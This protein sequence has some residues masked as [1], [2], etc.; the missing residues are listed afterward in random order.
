MKKK[1]S[2][3][4]LSLLL[5]GCNGQSETDK[6]PSES[7]V[8]PTDKTTTTTPAYTVDLSDI[9]TELSFGFSGSTLFKSGYDI[10]GFNENYHDFKI[11]DNVYEFKTQMKEKPQKALSK[12]QVS[13]PLMTKKSLIHPICASM[14]WN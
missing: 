8:P 14:N 4:F 3:L 11:G 10:L 12:T 6:L 2:L 1:I 7:V 5:V 9:I 13:T